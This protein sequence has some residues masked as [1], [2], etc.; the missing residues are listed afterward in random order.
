MEENK[1]ELHIEHLDEV[2]EPPVKDFSYMNDKHPVKPVKTPKNRQK[3][4]IILL[5]IILICLVVLI[6]LS[7]KNHKTTTKTSVTSQKTTT[8]VTINT[9]KAPDVQLTS[10]SSTNFNLTVSYPTG[11]KIADGTSSLTITSPVSNIVGADGQTVKGKTLI[12]VSS[13]GTLPA[14]IGNG[15]PTA[16]LASTIMKY[17]SP[18]SDQRAQTYVSFAQYSTTLSSSGL[19]AIFLTGDYGYTLGQT[20]PQSDLK[21]L[22]PIV[23][24]TFLK[25]NDIACTNTTPLTIN[26]S[27]WANLDFS[28][29][30]TDTLKSFTFI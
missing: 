11:W 19:D 27:N 23:S 18:S 4:I 3:H 22:D 5:V 12:S 7:Y 6:F 26:S 2:E 29:P 15:N 8:S 24:T 13:K 9:T 1:E 28:T 20:I 25:C 17:T 30:I 14:N 10:Y 21:N 16:V